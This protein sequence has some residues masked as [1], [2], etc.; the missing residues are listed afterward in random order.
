MKALEFTCGWCGTGVRIDDPLPAHYQQRFCSVVCMRRSIYERRKAAGRCPHCPEPAFPGG[1]TCAFHRRESQLRT[2]AWSA[3]RRGLP[4]EAIHAK[5][6]A[7]K[8]RWKQLRAAG[9]DPW[10]IAE[11]MMA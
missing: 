5:R 1:V 6:R 9:A 10:A 7:L 11:E 2:Q 4:V 3:A 8:A